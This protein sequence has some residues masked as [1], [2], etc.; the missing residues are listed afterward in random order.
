M[1]KLLSAINSGWCVNSRK[2]ICVLGGSAASLLLC[3]PIFA[4]VNTGRILR[5]VTD[6]SEEA[7]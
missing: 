6:Q 1:R 2:A 3:S 5:T 4:Q 7:I